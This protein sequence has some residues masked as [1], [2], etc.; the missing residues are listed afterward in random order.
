MVKVSLIYFNDRIWDSVF[1]SILQKKKNN[2]SES[3]GKSEA[4]YAFII[5]MQ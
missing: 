4:V 5:Y 2:L 3:G 1:A